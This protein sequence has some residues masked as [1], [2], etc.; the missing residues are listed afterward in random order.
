[1]PNPNT[2]SVERE[3]DGHNTHA[4]GASRKKV[5]P[6]EA[7]DAGDSCVGSGSPMNGGEEGGPCQ[8]EAFLTSLDVARFNSKDP[9][10]VLQMS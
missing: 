3:R 2:E 10:L 7:R 9:G 5:P 1:M 4:P 8:M 6:S